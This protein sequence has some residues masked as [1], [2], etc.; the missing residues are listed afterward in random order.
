MA[1]SHAAA[2]GAMKSEA[3]CRFL[4]VRRHRRL[5]SFH[6]CALARAQ[7]VSRELSPN[8]GR[9]AMLKETARGMI[10]TTATTQYEHTRWPGGHKRGETPD[11][12][13]TTTPQRSATQKYSTQVWCRLRLEPATAG[14][15]RCARAAQNEG[16]AW[17]LRRAWMTSKVS[18]Q[19]A[20]SRGGKGTGQSFLPHARVSACSVFLSSHLFASASGVLRVRGS[21][22]EPATPAD[23][24]LFAGC[25]RATHQWHLLDRQMGR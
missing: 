2:H 17:R 1:A 4:G 19:E 6:G 7:T 3:F 25:P 9:R 22:R 11:V 12:G 13:L 23:Q 10:T 16:V 5:A 14:L 20:V 18:H 21:Y 8:I 24:G 15:R